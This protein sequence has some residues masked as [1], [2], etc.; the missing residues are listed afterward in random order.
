MLRHLGLCAGVKG[1][2]GGPDKKAALLQ[3][4][5]FEWPLRSAM[6]KFCGSRRIIVAA[7][8]GVG[9]SRSNSILYAVFSFRLYFHASLVVRLLEVAYCA[10]G[11]APL[12]FNST[13]TVQNIVLNSVLNHWLGGLQLRVKTRE[14]NHQLRF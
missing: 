10:A 5:G 6:T 4:R 13:E 7:P 8:I 9:V 14:S 11:P 12:R 3:Y 2:C 1:L